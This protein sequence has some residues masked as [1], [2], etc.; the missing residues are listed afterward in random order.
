[1]AQFVVFELLK[2]RFA[3]MH[4]YDP[5][6]QMGDKEIAS[7]FSKKSGD[8]KVIVKKIESTNNMGVH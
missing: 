7:F 1:M 3:C 6:N 5:E 4:W 2:R 8:Y